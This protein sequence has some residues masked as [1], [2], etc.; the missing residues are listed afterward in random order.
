MFPGKSSLDRLCHRI[1]D[2]RIRKTQREYVRSVSILEKLEVRTGRVRFRS[3]G[4]RGSGKL[5]RYTKEELKKYMLKEIEI[6]QDIA[7][8]LNLFVDY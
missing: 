8:V 1:K 2:E 5:W 7:M 3:T 4:V 6:T